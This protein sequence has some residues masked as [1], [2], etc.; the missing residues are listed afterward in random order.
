MRKLLQVIAKYYVVLLFVLLELIGFLMLV[1]FNTFH[2]IAYLSWVNEVT[3]GVYKRVSN[4]TQ[5]LSLVEKNNE[6]QTENAFLRQQLISSYLHTSNNFNPY[7]DTTYHQN[8]F[9]RTGKVIDNK[10]SGTQN[11]LMI[12]KGLSAGIRKQ[13]GVIDAKGVIGVVTDV[14]KHY[15]VVMSTLNT[16]FTL[17]VRLRGQEYFGILSWDGQDTRIAKLKNIQQFVNVSKGDT[18]ETIGA[19]GIFP[20]GV[21]VG[22]VQHIQPED[23]TNNWDISVMLSSNLQQAKYVYVLENVFQSEIDSLTQDLP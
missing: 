20:E 9:F 16:D 17:G 15:A 2:Q 3:G 21:M 6:L 13:M 23:E 19:S 22:L 14:S 12:D 8:Y 4:L 1:R 5:H 18:I 7:I 11:Y 10:L